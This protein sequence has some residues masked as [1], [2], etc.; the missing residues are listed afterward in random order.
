MGSEVDYCLYWNLIS[1]KSIF[2]I[3][4]F[5][6]E[7]SQF[8]FTNKTFKKKLDVFFADFF[9]FENILI[10]FQKFPAKIL[11]CWL[12]KST[13]L[14]DFGK[15]IKKKTSQWVRRGRK[16]CLFFFF[17]FSLPNQ[18]FSEHRKDRFLLKPHAPYTRI[19]EC[20]SLRVPQDSYKNG[21]NSR[22]PYTPYTLGLG[23]GLGLG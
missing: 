10:Y 11:R 23:L 3:M 6:R 1:L 20:L 16:A 8:Y 18:N 4:P 17:F 22:I 14:Q 5:A 21:H 13:D 7:C 15:I 12:K 19:L 2:L 9:F